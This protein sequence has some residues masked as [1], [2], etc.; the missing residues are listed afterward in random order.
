[1][2]LAR[3]DDATY[4]AELEMA[5]A[6]VL[7]AQATLKHDDNDLTDLRAK[8]KLATSDWDRAKRLRPTEAMIG[9]AKLST[10]LKSS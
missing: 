4:K 9:G 5:K 10:C 8:L 1:M 6:Q 2:M 7:Q 3:I